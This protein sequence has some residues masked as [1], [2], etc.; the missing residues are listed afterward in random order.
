[1]DILGIILATG[2]PSAVMGF[3]VWLL[4][5]HIDKR[6]AKQ[7]RRTKSIE[8]LMMLIMKDSRSTNVLA[9]ATAKAVQ[10]IPDA[11]CNGDMTEALREAEEIQQ[12]EKDFFTKQGL[13]HLFDND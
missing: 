11:H 7:D 1:M 6:D 12:E 5:R 8:T 4:K 3:L 10:R 9:T 2:I 13:E